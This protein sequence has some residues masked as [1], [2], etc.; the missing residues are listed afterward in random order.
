VSFSIVFVVLK[1]LKACVPML[2]KVTFAPT[3]IFGIT[4]GMGLGETGSLH[5][6]ME[7]TTT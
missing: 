6:N 1:T 2:I 7:N 5:K 4:N 3:S